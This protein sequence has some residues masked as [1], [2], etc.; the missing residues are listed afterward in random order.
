MQ[1]CAGLGKH[2]PHNC[3]TVTIILCFCLDVGQNYYLNS[4][5]NAL[6][7]FLNTSATIF[8]GPVSQYICMSALHLVL[9]CLV[10]KSSCGSGVIGDDITSS[11]LATLFKLSLSKLNNKITRF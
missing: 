7:V 9:Y 8:F 5:G 2:Y 11:I 6:C 4:E 1:S 3:V 10:V